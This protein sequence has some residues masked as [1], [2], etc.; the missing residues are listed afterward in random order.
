MG[1][2]LTDLGFRVLE[3]KGFY[4]GHSRKIL[5]VQGSRSWDMG[6]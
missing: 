5:H 1:L 6:L 3:A 4:K 2:G